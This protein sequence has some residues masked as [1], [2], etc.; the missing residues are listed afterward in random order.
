[1]QYDETAHFSY[2][3]NDD[4]LPWS[5]TGKAI[6]GTALLEENFW[7]LPVQLVQ[8]SLFPVDYKRSGLRF[9]WKSSSQVILCDASISGL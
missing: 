3:S 4:F 1:M 2:I 6:V 5:Y 8:F 7:L 9:T